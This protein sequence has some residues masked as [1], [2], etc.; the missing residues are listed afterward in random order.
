MSHVGV[1]SA[2]AAGGGGGG[3]RQGFVVGCQVQSGQGRCSRGGRPRVQSQR[4]GAEEKGLHVGEERVAE[5]ETY[6]RGL[7][8]E[9]IEIS[10]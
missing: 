1:H 5:K 10:Y 4:D 2:A 3:N 7:L 9:I 8:I 6:T